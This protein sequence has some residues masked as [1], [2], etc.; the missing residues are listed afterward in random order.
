MKAEK[1]FFST[2]EVARF[3]LEPGPQLVAL[4]VSAVALAMRFAFCSGRVSS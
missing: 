2:V 4:A 1:R 3:H